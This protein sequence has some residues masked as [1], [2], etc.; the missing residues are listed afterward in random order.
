MIT[1]PPPPIKYVYIK[2]LLS[3]FL[4]TLP[5]PHP[6]QICTFKINIPETFGDLNDLNLNNIFIHLCA[7][8]VFNYEICVW[9]LCKNS[10]ERIRKLWSKKTTVEQYFCLFDDVTVSEFNECKPRLK[11]PKNRFQLSAGLN[12]EILNTI[13]SGTN[14]IWAQA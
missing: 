2:Y 1:P 9:A 5:R 4:I 12:L 10:T 8:I 3:F 6:Q 13:W 11:S 14:H 7:W